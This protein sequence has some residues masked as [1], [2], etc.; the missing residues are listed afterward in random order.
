MEQADNKTDVLLEPVAHYSSGYYFL[1]FALL[2]VCVWGAYAFAVQVT[3]GIGVLG[4]RSEVMWG[5]YITN[6]VF[7]IGISHVGAL[8]S[9]I[10]R[11][12]SADWR[13]PVTR[14]AEVVTFASLLAAVTWPIAHLGRPD[15]FMN[16]FLYPK[17]QSPLVWDLLC[18][19]TYM[20][21]S[22]IFL[23]LPM[24]PDIAKC[25]DQLT[26]VSRFRKW[27][28]SILSLGWSGSEYE[29]K[30]LERAIGIMT[31]LIVPIAISVHT[32]VS[33]D[34]A[35][36]LRTGW[37]STIFGPYF[38]AGAL[39]SG[40]ATVV[41]VMAVLTK[42]Y[43]LGDFI[44]RKH[45]DYMGAL[46]LALD[47]VLIYFT[48]NEYMVPGY[49][50]LS[51]NTMEGQW[52]SSLLWGT[53]WPRFWF[54]I[55]GGLILP[56]VIIAVPKT[57]TVT[58][59]LVAALLV[60]IGMWIERFNIVVASTAVPQLP[61]AWGLYTPTWVEISTT[62]ASFAGFTLVYLVF[63][64]TFPII[65]IWETEEPGSSAGTKLSAKI[66][67]GPGAALI[68]GEGTS[69]LI[70]R[71]GLLNYGALVVT[72]F[73]LGS[74]LPVIAKS[75]VQ[76]VKKNSNN[77]VPISNFG[78]SVSVIDAG[79]VAKFQVEKPA[80]IPR[81]SQLDEVRVG[82]NGELVTLLYANPSLPKISMY[83]GDVGVAILEMIEP[84]PSASPAYLPEGFKRVTINR[85]D[86]FAKEASTSD[87]YDRQE[88]GQLQ[89]WQGEVHFVVLANLPIE[90]LK[91]IAESMEPI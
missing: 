7:F 16:L 60:D 82:S 62:A 87:F 88:P 52:L 15:R 49:K 6:F 57:R 86:G 91:E 21:G 55:I 70:S 19:G 24:I 28:Y 8:M 31:I 46:L 25:R 84:R 12:T 90:Q 11:L 56:A 80:R 66:A 53:Y 73:A 18:I 76:G 4:I 69:S 39:L 58:G 2:A 72:G 26:N 77:I 51:Q 65:S 20:I 68:S 74:T 81:G 34:F 1:A 35:M 9:A 78:K 71:R 33:W 89:W 43:H 67:F 54:Q 44:T 75:L 14:V 47:I 83:T 13:K 79:S 30:H 42:F 3:N 22:T 23:Y 85:N 17:L 29:L 64:R 37:D 36:Q 48:I 40:V 5:V 59:Y 63:T 50:I 38:V 32:I 45:F 61:Y 10:L 41:L 27:I